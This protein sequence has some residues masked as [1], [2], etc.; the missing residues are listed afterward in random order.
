MGAIN[1]KD[2]I[3]R[4]NRLNNEIWYDGEK[5]E[6]LLSEHPAFKGLIQSKAALYDLQHDPKIKDEMTFISPVSGELI[7]LSYLQPKTKEDLIRRR[8]MTEHWARYSGGIMGRSP[9]YLNTVLMS[10]ALFSNLFKK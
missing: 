9:D 3:N 2:Y 5:I 4:L 10:F 6:G 8:K 1:G 7:G